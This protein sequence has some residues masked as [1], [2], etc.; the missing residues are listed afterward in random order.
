MT[1]NFTQIKGLLTD[2]SQ[3]LDKN[4]YYFHLQLI[5]RNKDTGVGSNS[6]CLKAYQIDS[7]HPL[8]MYEDDIIEFC[9]RFK[10][11]AY[12]NLSPKSKEATAVQMLNSLADCFRQR[13]FKHINRIWNSAAGKVGAL[14]KYW[15]LDCD[16][17]NEKD[18]EKIVQFVEDCCMPLDKTKC[19]DI[20]PTKNGVHVITTPFDLRHFHEIYPSIDIHKNNPTVLY[21]PDF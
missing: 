7:D 6:T 1:N 11:R 9:N 3:G 13:D 10:A 5:R 19:I 18:A 17:C 14:K 12:I 16:G 4:D 20:I 21:V 15:V 8:D 2:F